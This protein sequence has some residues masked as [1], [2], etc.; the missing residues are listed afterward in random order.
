MKKAR[1]L[2]FSSTGSGA[3]IGKVVA[4]NFRMVVSDRPRRI[5]RSRTLTSMP[6]PMPAMIWKPIQFRVALSACS[7]LCNP[8]PTTIHAHA[9]TFCGLYLFMAVA[10]PP[11]TI[12]KGAIDKL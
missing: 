10:V 7:V 4:V 8:I 2:A 6:K 3:R 11:A 12:A 9:I 5:R 1:A